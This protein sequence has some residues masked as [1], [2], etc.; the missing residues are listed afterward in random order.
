M[1][2]KVVERQNYFLRSSRH[3][4]EFQQFSRIYII[5]APGAG[6]GSLCTKLATD[7]GFHHLS[8]GDLLRKQE[9][10]GSLRPDL[11]RAIQGSAL[12]EVDD[13]VSILKHAVEE[14]SNAGKRRL[15]IDGVPRS[16]D[17]IEHIEAAVGSPDLVFFFDCPE[18][19][20]KQRF[21]TRNIPGRFGDAETFHARYKHYVGENNQIVGHY[22]EK[23]VLMTVDT[24]G[25]IESSYAK[26]LEALR[27][28]G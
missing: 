10:S 3:R 13:L 16:F 22:Q 5:G 9:A 2:S 8:V 17:Q 19:L 11:V 14:L 28:R 15:L 7:H 26:L 21:L 18:D 27:S 6:K 12:L 23:G 4:V 24:S 25:N 20:A 1:P